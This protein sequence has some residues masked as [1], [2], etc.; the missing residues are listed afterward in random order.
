MK[1]LN[2]YRVAKCFWEIYSKFLKEN[3]LESIFSLNL[4]LRLKTVFSSL[5]TS[6]RYCK[7]ILN[8]YFNIKIDDDK[9]IIPTS[10]RFFVLKQNFST[11]HVKAV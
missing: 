4:G 11:H 5:K 9:K 3:V 6:K 10:D 7:L 2:I 8:V 1:I